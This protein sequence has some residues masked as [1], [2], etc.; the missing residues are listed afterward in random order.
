PRRNRRPACL[1]DCRPGIPASRPRP[2]AASSHAFRGPNKKRTAGVVPGPKSAPRGYRAWP[3][4]SEDAA[5]LLCI[6]PGRPPLASRQAR[7]AAD[8]TTAYN[9]RFPPIRSDVG[10]V[11]RQGRR[12]STLYRRRQVPRRS[13]T[14]SPSAWDEGLEVHG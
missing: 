13:A 1:S 11:T 2:F 3:F 14:D 9:I 12:G 8:V 10:R 7:L 6:L 4:L 5:N